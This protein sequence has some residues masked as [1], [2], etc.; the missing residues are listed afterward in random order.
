MQPIKKRP[1]TEK[2]VAHYTDCSIYALRDA[3]RP[4]RKANA[5]DHFMDG[6]K[7]LYDPEEVISWAKS[8]G[9]IFTGVWIDA[10]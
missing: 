7:V 8:A 9:K 2:E 3:R 4:D 1:L 10:K 5:P 6:G